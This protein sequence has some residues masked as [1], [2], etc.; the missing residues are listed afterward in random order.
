[1][2]RSDFGPLLI[3]I[4]RDEVVRQDTS[5]PLTTLK[6]LIAS[7]ENIRANMLNVDV[8]FSGYENTSAELFEIPEVRNYVYALDAHFPFWLYFLSRHFLGLQC[9]AYCHLLPYLTPEARARS[10]PQKLAE[11]V[12]NRW[13]PALFQICSAAGHTETEAVA[14]LES[15]ME[16]FASGPSRLIEGTTKEDA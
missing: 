9:F 15:A 13:G 16:Y 11:L 1:M 14:L 12:E 6:H 5:G 3:I 4:S 7:P 10:H 8:S 2:N